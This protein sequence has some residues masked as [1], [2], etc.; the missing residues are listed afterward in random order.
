M[1]SPLPTTHALEM[2]SQ[3]LGSLGLFAE[4]FQV[5]GG[6]LPVNSRAI[7]I[8]EIG[9]EGSGDRRHEFHDGLVHYHA[10]AD[11]RVF[12]LHKGNG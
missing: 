5:L 1:T 6:V 8:A 7:W 2:M 12:E 4:V 11:A 9:L 10:L 3:I